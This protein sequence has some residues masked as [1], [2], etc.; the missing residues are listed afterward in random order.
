MVAA[1]EF[2]HSDHVAK[3]GILVGFGTVKLLSVDHGNGLFEAH[4]ETFHVAKVW[5]GRNLSAQLFRVLSHSSKNDHSALGVLRV[6]LILQEQVA[7]QEMAKM[8][9]SNALLKSIL[10]VAR[11]LSDRQVDGG[12]CNDAINRFAHRSEIRDELPHVGHRRQIAVHRGVLA[13]RNTN[14]GSFGIHLLDVAHGTDHVPSHVGKGLSRPQ[15]NARRSA[16]DN[17]SSGANRIT[18]TLGH[19]GNEIHG[20]ILGSRNEHGRFNR[21]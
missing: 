1:V 16:S 9:S 10:G 14:L 18:F 11:L 20:G 12:I 21:A 2:A 6:L 7:Q 13:L 8:I 5:L 15:A 3:L 19:C 4:F 17:H